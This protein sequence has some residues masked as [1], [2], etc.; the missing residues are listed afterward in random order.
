MPI[1]F[2]CA[3]C[4]QLL[5]IARRKAGQVVRCPT[6]AGQ[7][8]VP[9]AE[10]EPAPAPAGD[11]APP[12]LFERSDFEDVFNVPATEQP[13]PAAAAGPVAAPSPGHPVTSW[14]TEGEVPGI[15]VERAVPE[16]IPPPLPPVAPALP[17]PGIILSPKKATVLTVVVII[18]I[19]VAFLA[20]VL[21]GLALH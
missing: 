15:D 12:P 7:V 3:Y 21:V 14:P 16:L 20:G 2:R 18:I 17:G 9:E 10:E 6:C 5:G 8:I 19:A 13:Q 1:R 11:G 4:N